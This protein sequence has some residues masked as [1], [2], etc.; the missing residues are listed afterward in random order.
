M[1]VLLCIA[2]AA[3]VTVDIDAAPRRFVTV[4]AG[5]QVSED[6]GL[7]ASDEQRCGFDCGFFEATYCDDWEKI[8]QSRNAIAKADQVCCGSIPKPCLARWAKQGRQYCSSDS[9]CLRPSCAQESWYAELYQDTAAK[10]DDK[11]C[12]FGSAESSCASKDA[13]FQ[14]VR[15]RKLVAVIDADRP[16]IYRALLERSQ[17]TESTDPEDDDYDWGDSGL[18]HK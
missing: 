14:L 13:G 11:S 8:V 17:R 12:L 5:A 16:A 1:F 15:A 10:V 6:C 9:K 7:G 3:A 2:A 4:N 18:A